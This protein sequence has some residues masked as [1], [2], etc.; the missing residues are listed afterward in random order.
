MSLSRDGDLRMR[1]AELSPK[2]LLAVMSEMLN[3]LWQV[4]WAQA[5]LPHI[6]A[7]EGAGL[8]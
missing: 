5:L 4:F 6:H 7:V 2:Q 3:Y 1:A 8:C